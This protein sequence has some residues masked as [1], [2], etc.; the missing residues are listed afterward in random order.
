MDERRRD[1]GR[2]R[3]LGPRQSRARGIVAGI[4]DTGIN[5]DHPSFAGTGPV[6]GYVHQN[7]RTRFYGLC[8]GAPAGPA[9]NN[10]LIGMYDFLGGTGVDDN[11][12]GSHTASTVAGNVVD[13]TLVAPL[14]TLA[15]TRISGVAPAREHHFLPR[16]PVQEPRC[17]SSARARSTP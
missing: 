17:R 10:K 4:I 15:P 7:P 12:H 6:D 14:I 16:L 11:G 5:P 13:A 3:R 9:C 8:G 1:L 2:Q